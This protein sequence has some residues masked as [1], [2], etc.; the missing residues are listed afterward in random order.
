M[1]WLKMCTFPYAQYL[2]LRIYNANP[3]LETLSLL[4]KYLN[5][6][7]DSVIFYDKPPA[8]PYIEQI[9]Y[10]LNDCT[11]EEKDL[12]LHTLRGLLD[13]LRKQK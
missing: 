3:R 6:S 11:D 10:E 12:A 8:N 9:I 1:L 13:G 4:A 5:I 7:L 2:I